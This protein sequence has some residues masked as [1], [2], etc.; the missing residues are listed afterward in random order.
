[1][2][3]EKRHLLAATVVVALSTVL[4]LGGVMDKVY[5]QGNQGG[6]Q[7]NGGQGDDE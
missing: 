1:M 6:G 7:C 2:M 4:I 3:R 5:A